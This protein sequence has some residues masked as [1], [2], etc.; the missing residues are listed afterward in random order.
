MSRWLQY[1]MRNKVIT[2]AVFVNL[3]S[4]GSLWLGNHPI[5][6]AQATVSSV[7]VHKPF[8]PAAEIVKGEPQRIFIP[9]L[10]LN[11]PIERG[12]FDK[13]SESWTLSADHAH[14]AAPSALANNYAGNTLVYGHY[15]RKVFMALD[16]LRP[17]MKAEIVTTNGDHF[18][19]TYTNADVVAPDDTSVFS[20]KGDPTLTLQTCTGSWYEKRR[21]SHFRFDKVVIASASTADYQQRQDKLMK[22]LD[23]LL[24]TPKLTLTE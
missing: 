21:L 10:G 9:D 1:M 14:F 11:L 24:E 23:G 5:H 6:S 4:L 22:G 8:D 13:V 2:I 20:L 19:Y 7:R 12:Y 18:Y 3:G 16:N 17:G 15:N